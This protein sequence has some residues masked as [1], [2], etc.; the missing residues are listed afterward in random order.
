VAL[1][2]DGVVTI[3]DVLPQAP[4]RSVRSVGRTRAD[5]V[6]DAEREAVENA[7]RSSDGNRERAAEI[8]NISPTTLWRKMT[9]LGITYDAKG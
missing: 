7:L 1:C 8:L 9:R 5:I 2:S 3:D 4:R 6:D